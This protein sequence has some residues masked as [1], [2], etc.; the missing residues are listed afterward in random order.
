MDDNIIMAVNSSMLDASWTAF[1]PLYGRFG[2]QLL[3]RINI[4]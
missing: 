4:A 1:P 3:S 2:H